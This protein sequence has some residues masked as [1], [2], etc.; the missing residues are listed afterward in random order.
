MQNLNRWL[1]RTLLALCLLAL[2]LSAFAQD[3]Y[4]DYTTTDGNVSFAHPEGWGVLE[5]EDGTIAISNIE[6]IESILQSDAPDP[7]AGEYG[8]LMVFFPTEFLSFLVP[9]LDLAESSVEEVGAAVITAFT[10]EP[11]ET[12]TFGETATTELPSG[13]TISYVTVALDTTAFGYF[14]AIPGDG[15]IAIIQGVSAVDDASTLE[16][17]Y[18]NIVD[19]LSFTVP[20]EDLFGDSDE[21]DDAP[22]VVVE[23]TGADLGTIGFEIS[24][25]DDRAQVVADA[26]WL[27][28][29]TPPIFS[30]SSTPTFDI[31]LLTDFDGNNYISLQEIAPDIQP[32][33]YSLSDFG[34]P[35][36]YIQTS[37]DNSFVGSFATD[38]TLVI[39]SVDGGLISGSVNFV[40]EDSFDEDPTTFARAVF[41][42]IQI[43]DV[44]ACRITSDDADATFS[45]TAN[46]APEFLDVDVAVDGGAW[47]F[48]GV[49]AFDSFSARGGTYNL[50]FAEGATLDDIGQSGVTISFTNLT[51][52]HLEAGEY[53]VGTDDFFDEETARAR[54]TVIGTGSYSSRDA[55][56]TLTITESDGTTISGEYAL[57]VLADDFYEEDTPEG[58][59]V[60]EFNG[61]FSGL[62]IPQLDCQVRSGQ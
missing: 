57:T 13:T 1:T 25:R 16:P 6:D 18:F 5:D 7:A 8:V 14:T 44:A 59:V 37:L 36:G 61:S 62:T 53:Q 11:D 54:I 39:D 35:S 47:A 9:D 31:Y 33:T 49:N 43:P 38:G 34:G 32:G 51:P 58:T 30:F 46:S 12:V 28:Q 48:I 52:T 42:D 19:S 15:G 41:T 10:E 4:T 3:G 45:F 23:D 55:F 17:I 21:T 56:G 50:D 27:T 24:G 2:P 26:A 22:P 20:S 40:S 29:P 60:A